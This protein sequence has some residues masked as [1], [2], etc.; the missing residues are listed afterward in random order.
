MERVRNLEIAESGLIAFDKNATDS[1]TIGSD[2]SI[3]LSVVHRAVA[4]VQPPRYGNR[5]L[6]S[7]LSC[8]H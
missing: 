2:L 6:N 3:C 8:T 4:L 5:V 7:A 1:I